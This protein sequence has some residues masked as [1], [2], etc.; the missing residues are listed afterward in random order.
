MMPAFQKFKGFI[1]RVIAPFITDL[2]K[3]FENMINRIINGLNKF[4]D[5]LNSLTK[6]AAKVLKALGF[7][8]DA[9]QIS[10][11]GNVDFGLEHFWILNTT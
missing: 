11:I 6:K 3:L 10:K 4:I 2:P 5:R 1:E 8:V 9:W 7:D